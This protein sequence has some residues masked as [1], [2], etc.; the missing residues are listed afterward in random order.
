[1]IPTIYSINF[2]TLSNH[3]LQIRYDCL[4]ESPYLV[5]EVVADRLWRVKYEFVKGSAGV[6]VASAL[7]WNPMDPDFAA[8]VLSG[9]SQYGEKAVEVAHKDIEKAIDVFGRETMSDLE[10]MKSCSRSM[11]SYVVKLKSGS[12]LLYAP[13]K[14]RDETGFGQWMDSLGT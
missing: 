4:G 12:L 14:V 7:G 3:R 1:M 6:R 8:N 10:Y 11:N 13:V 2:S 9:A 5:T